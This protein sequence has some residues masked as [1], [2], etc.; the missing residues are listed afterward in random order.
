[1]TCRVRGKKQ[2]RGK[3]EHREANKKLRKKE[4]KR[5]E[6]KKEKYRKKERMNNNKNII[7]LSISS[8][9]TLPKYVEILC[10]NLCFENKRRGRTGGITAPFLSLWDHNDDKESI[11][12]LL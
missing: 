1:M 7:P 10:W 4:K 11:T 3:K 9:E 2:E 6:I 8:V 5:T 12:V